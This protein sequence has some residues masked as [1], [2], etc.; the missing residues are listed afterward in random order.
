L[1]RRRAR[2]KKKLKD[3]LFGERIVLY[4]TR[5]AEAKNE[6]SLEAKN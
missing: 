2:K 6:R 4:R 3:F 5:K 1:E